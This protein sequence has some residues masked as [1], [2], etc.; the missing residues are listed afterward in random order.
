MLNKKIQTF[1]GQQKNKNLFSNLY[2]QKKKQKKR[3]FNFKK[4]NKKKTF[5]KKKAMHYC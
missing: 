5:T 3:Q 1:S 4:K 2:F